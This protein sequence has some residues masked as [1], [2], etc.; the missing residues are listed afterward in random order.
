MSSSYPNPPIV[1]AVCEF[2]F[3]AE[4]EWDIS[5]PGIIYEKLKSQYPKKGTHHNYSIGVEE[6]EKATVNKHERIRLSDENESN[7]IQIGERFLSVNKL[8]PYLGW[9]DYKAKIL[10][11]LEIFNNVSGQYPIKN[12]VLRYI[13]IFSF[14]AE[15][16]D[17][18]T[19]ALENYFEVRPY[20][21]EGIGRDYVTFFT[22]LQF[23]FEGCGKNPENAD[24]FLKVEL[25]NTPSNE[26][27]V[28][29]I[30]Q[31]LEYSTRKSFSE[32]GCE[33]GVWLEK[34]HNDLK[35]IFE[36]SITENLR[37]KFYQ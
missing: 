37:A 31:N 1:E 30:R 8:N 22:G 32:Q 25:T 29:K 16:F 12:I 23:V 21:G 4:E 28:I 36:R 33:P 26:E 18:D 34:A 6:E 9:E 10:N 15:D 35:Y 14:T 3:S 17:G 24:N 27:N 7:L 19:L 20:R 5:I 11:A 13:N 2:H